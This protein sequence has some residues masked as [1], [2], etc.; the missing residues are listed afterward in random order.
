MLCNEEGRRPSLRKALSKSS[1]VLHVLVKTMMESAGRLAR[2]SSTIWTKKPF[3]ASKG[4]RTKR[5]SSW[6]TVAVSATEAHCQVC[7]LLG[8]A[9][10]VWWIMGEVVA[11][12]S[13][14]CRLDGTAA[15]MVT[16]W[17]SNP[18]DENDN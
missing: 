16:S 8:Q 17:E 18:P 1:A 14:V 7:G 11:V 5:W 9:A 10:M 13:R 12:K 2:T 4:V 3:L 15:R 6:L